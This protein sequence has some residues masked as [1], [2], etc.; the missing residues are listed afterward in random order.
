[1]NFKNKVIVITGASSGLGKA[2]ARSLRKSGCRVIASSN[3]KAE[4]KN[5]ARELDIFSFA[6]DV[7]KERDVADLASFA[8]KKFGR[9]D[10]WVNN[11]GITTLNSTLEKVD[12]KEAHQVM[13]VNF[14]GTVYGT[15]SALKVMKGQR[16]GTIVN[17][18]SVRAFEKD[19]RLGIYSASKWAVRGFTEGLMR[20]VPKLKGISIIAVYPGAMK[21]K[22]HGRH[23]PAGY[24]SF[25]EPEFV[26]DK[27]VRNLGK[28]K[29]KTEFIIRN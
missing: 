23:H 5:V 18:I 8:L 20:F 1:M 7:A 2:L 11:A 17:I 22:L 19:V 13:D 6:A 26:A 24:K 14:F 29:P 15:L 10:I 9:I 4:L 12:V 3:N 21:T 28:S 16:S 27:I 25:M